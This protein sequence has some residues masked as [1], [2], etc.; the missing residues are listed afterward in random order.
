MSY[1]YTSTVA[2]KLFNFDSTLSNLNVSDCL[3]NPQ[4]CQCK[5][6]KFCYEPH[7]NVISGDLKVIENVKLREPVAKDTEIQ[8]TKYGQLEGN[9]N[10]VFGIHR[11]LCKKLAQ[12]RTSR[13]KYLSEWKDQ[14]KEL[15]ADCISNLKGHF[16]SP[17]CKVLDQPDV[18]DSLRTKISWTITS[19]L[20][21]RYSNVPA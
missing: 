18:K 19:R 4:T 13:L 10:N 21:L 12:K 20:I 5:E 2:S 6:F 7:G 8:R 11:S 14:L 16:K 3:S 9:R 15:V 17:K 1:E